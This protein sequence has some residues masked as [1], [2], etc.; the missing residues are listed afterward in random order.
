MSFEPPE[1]LNDVDRIDREW[2]RERERY[3]VTTKYGRRYVPSTGAAVVVGLISVSVGLIWTMVAFSMVQSLGGAA[4]IFPLFGM[5]FVIGGAAISI[6]QFNRGKQY[7]TAYRAYQ[8]RR[9]T[10]QDSLRE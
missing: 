9:S 2:E 3:M 8:R 5:V 6:Y 4:G 1:K 10:A 7:Q